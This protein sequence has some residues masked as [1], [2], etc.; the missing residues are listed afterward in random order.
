MFTRFISKILIF[1]FLNNRKN[2]DAWVI[3]KLNK[4]PKGK[5][6]LDAGAGQCKYKEHSSHLNYTSQDFCQYGKVKSQSDRWDYSKIDIV[7]DILDIPVDGESFDYIL[8]TEVLEHVPYPDRAVKEF[9]RVLKKGGKLILT[10]PFASNVHMAPF[11][12]FTGF[13]KYWYEQVLQDE[14]F[15]ILE[16]KSNGN[17]SD[18]LCEKLIIA[19][20][21]LRKYS[22][23]GIAYY[24]IYLFV[25]PLVLVIHLFSKL[26]RESGQESCFGY[27]VLAKK[28]RN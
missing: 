14:G 11:Y 2:R 27:Y 12:Y 10:V 22:V 19:P 28:M 24:L 13:S 9:R 16:L 21:I 1:S 25:L 20:I 8:C 7:S 23:I 26:I 18:Y 6:L 15:K 5:R 3:D 4:I 17:F